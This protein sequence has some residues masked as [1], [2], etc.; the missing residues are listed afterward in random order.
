LFFA[1][2]PLFD[3]F[4]DNPAD[5]TADGVSN[6]FVSLK[7]VIEIGVPVRC[8]CSAMTC[9]PDGIDEV[10]E[11]GKSPDFRPRWTTGYL[12]HHIEDVTVS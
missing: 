10:L 7:R 3:V 6:L 9:G 5:E 2:R 8:L 11:A 1:G 4:P 12:L